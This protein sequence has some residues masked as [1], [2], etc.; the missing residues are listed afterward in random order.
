M[1]FGVLVGM[2]IN[3]TVIWVNKMAAG[4][5]APQDVLIFKIFIIKPYTKIHAVFMGMILANL[6]EEINKYKNKKQS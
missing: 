2:A 4:L 6:F 5:F 1:T 3:F